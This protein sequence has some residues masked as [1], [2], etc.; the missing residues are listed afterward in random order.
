MRWEGGIRLI[1][2]IQV[3]TM[4]RMVGMDG[5][6]GIGLKRMRASSWW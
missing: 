6:I 2:G 1:D 3:R 5:L 4:I